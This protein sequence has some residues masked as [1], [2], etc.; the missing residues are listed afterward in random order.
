MCKLEESS[1][2]VALSEDGLAL[3]L[4]SEE[5]QVN[6]FGSVVTWRRCVWLEVRSKNGSSSVGCRFCVF[7]S[8]LGVLQCD[9]F[10]AL[11]VSPCGSPGSL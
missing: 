1:G 11:V 5:G 8:F 6:E 2:E 9:S 4:C 3:L 10:V 7:Q